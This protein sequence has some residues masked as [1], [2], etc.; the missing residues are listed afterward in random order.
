MFILDVDLFL[1]PKLFFLILFNG[2]YKKSGSEGDVHLDTDFK[3]SNS[4]LCYNSAH[5]SSCEF[6]NVLSSFHMGED[7]FV[8]F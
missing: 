4:P 1:F 2:H 6:N 5:D 8:Y 3:Y 7:G